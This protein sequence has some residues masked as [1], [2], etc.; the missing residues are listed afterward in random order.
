[1]TSAMLVEM[2]VASSA[3]LVYGEAALYSTIW[4]QN[5]AIQ[6]VKKIV[7]TRLGTAVM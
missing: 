2:K 3:H 5:L 7:A 6:N 4:R 1:M